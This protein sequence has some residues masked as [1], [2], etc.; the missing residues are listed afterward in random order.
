VIEQCIAVRF[1]WKSVT[2]VTDSIAVSEYCLG[3]GFLSSG[4]KHVLPPVQERQSR[5]QTSGIQAAD[6]SDQLQ[7]LRLRTALGALPECCR[8]ASHYLRLD[9]QQ[10]RDHPARRIAANIAK[11]PELLLKALIRIAP[12]NPSQRMRPRHVAYVRFVPKADI[13]ASPAR[14]RWTSRP[15]HQAHSLQHPAMPICA[16]SPDALLVSGPG[17][18]VSEHA[19]SRQGSLRQPGFAQA[20]FVSGEIFRTTER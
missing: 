10:P 13:R 14:C 20:V 6:R 11:L 2:P 12:L 16:V 3:P 4:G 15:R 9:R 1:A 8:A 7:R 18:L 17:E 5:S 19:T